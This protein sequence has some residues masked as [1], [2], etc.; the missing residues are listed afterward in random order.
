[1]LRLVAMS[2]PVAGVVRVQ[3]DHCVASVWDQYGVL[4]WW[5]VEGEVDE[6]A[7]SPASIVAEIVRAG[8]VWRRCNRKYRISSL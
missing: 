5:S 6:A 1:M 4:E 3:P 2:H 7:V 8:Y